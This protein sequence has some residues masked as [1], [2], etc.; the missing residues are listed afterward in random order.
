MEKIPIFFFRCRFVSGTAS[1][2]ALSVDHKIPSTPGVFL[3]SLVVTLFT[4]IAFA[5]KELQS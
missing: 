3:L 2:F 5:A 1:Y 4:A